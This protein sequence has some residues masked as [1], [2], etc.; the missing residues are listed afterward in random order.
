M[1]EVVEVTHDGAIRRCALRATRLAKSF[2]RSGDVLRGVDLRAAPGTLTVVV[3]G[4]TSGRTTLIRCLAGTYRATSGLIVLED[5]GTT[6]EL[7]AAG[8]REIA[9]ARRHRL[10]VFDGPPVAPP[11]TRT[12]TAVSRLAGVPERAARAGFARLG[13]DELSETTIGGLRGD[14]ACQ[15]GLVAALVSRAPILLLDDPRR[16]LVGPGLDEGGT[17]RR[18]LEGWLRDRRARGDT[19]VVTSSEAQ[20]WEADDVGMLDK[21]VIRWTTG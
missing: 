1:S 12:T 20:G 16:A 2:P 5:G 6:V 21:G 14:E 4:R 11:R 18:A 3:G 8:A 15:V 9:W 7:G 19:I 17:G 10:A 13:R